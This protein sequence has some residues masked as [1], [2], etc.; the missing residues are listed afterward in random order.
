MIG[1]VLTYDHTGI[2]GVCGQTVG[3]DGSGQYAV[4]FLG[5]T[6]ETTAEAARDYVKKWLQH[7]YIKNIRIVSAL[8]TYSGIPLQVVRV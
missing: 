7:A 2:R 5:D 8:E 4:V 1:T 6:A 3:A